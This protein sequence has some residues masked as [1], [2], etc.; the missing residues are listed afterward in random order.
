MTK[1][2]FSGIARTDAAMEMPP[3]TA[4]MAGRES[5][6]LFKRNFMANPNEKMAREK[7]CSRQ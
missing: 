5:I 4:S 2:D 6:F 3:A 1:I 7:K